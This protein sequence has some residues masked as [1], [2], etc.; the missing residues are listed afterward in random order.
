MHIIRTA[1][2]MARALDSPLPS[3]PKD[4][5]R[6]HAERLAAYEDFTLDELAVFAVVQPG[7]AL[8]DI[9]D[10]LALRLVA[11]DDFAI[12]PEVIRQ[13]GE[14]VEAVFILSDDGFGLVLL[15]ELGEATD[16][17]LATA[18]GNHLGRSNSAMND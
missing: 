7:D 1:E 11:N 14:W 6:Q 10:Q 8:C 4:H 2:D 9:E 16:R 12:T 3:I 18:C 5:L 17:N 13:H 15:I